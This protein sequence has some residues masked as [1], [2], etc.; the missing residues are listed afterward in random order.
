MAGRIFAVGEPVYDLAQDLNMGVQLDAMGEQLDTLSDQY[1][2]LKTQTTHLENEIAKISEFSDTADIQTL[3]G[4]VNELIKQAESYERYNDASS[5]FSQNYKGFIE[6]TGLLKSPSDYDVIYK[7][8]VNMTLQTMKNSND[9]IEKDLNDPSNSPKNISKTVEQA[10]FDIRNA[11]GTTQAVSG[12]A[13]INAQILKQLQQMHTQLAAMVES[14]NAA[15]AK[16]I[17]EEAD[18]MAAVRKK[19]DD[20]SNNQVDTKYGTYGLNMPKF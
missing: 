15:E 20:E 19:I 6:D 5:Q 11:A 14:Q 10:K 2:E 1:T 17:Q 12:L 3:L 18:G 7:E 16:K 8:N 4:Q 13:E 9:A